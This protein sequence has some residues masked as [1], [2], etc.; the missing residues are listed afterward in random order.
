MQVP[1]IFHKRGNHADGRKKGFDC[2]MQFHKQVDGKYEF[3]LKQKIAH[4]VGRKQ[5]LKKEE[6]K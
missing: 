2:H 5:V 1:Q 3:D 4:T 6:L